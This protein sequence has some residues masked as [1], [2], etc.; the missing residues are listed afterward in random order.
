MRLFAG[1]ATTPLVVKI[2]TKEHWVKI[3][4]LR[5]FARNFALSRG[6]IVIKVARI[7]NFYPGLFISNFH[8]QGGCGATCKYSHHV[9]NFDT[10][11]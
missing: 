11:V 1:G 7:F 5:N 6:K 3:E 10:V 2:L 8:H 4:N 9:E